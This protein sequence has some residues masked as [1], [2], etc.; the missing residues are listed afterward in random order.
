M[1]LPE[2][3]I[4]VDVETSGPI[5]EEYSMLALGA[6][7]VGDTARNFY[8]EFV[9]LNDNYTEQ[10]MQ[11]CD[12]SLSE[13]RAR[14]T[15]PRAAMEQFTAWLKSVADGKYPV[16]VGFNAPFDWSFVNYYF[17]KYG[18]VDANPF[19]HT[20]ADIKA[21]YMGAFGTTWFDTGMRRLPPEIHPP[22]RPLAH[23]ALDDAIQQA[24]IFE[25]LL[26]SRNPNET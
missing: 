12:L 24:D 7:V 19:G 1:P 11:T 8:V 14:G 25:K 15:E 21:Y 6:C 10:A 16:F 26:K 18:G 17:I 13:L 20:A 5:P 22:D 23:N 4:S 2:L 3:Y 9:P